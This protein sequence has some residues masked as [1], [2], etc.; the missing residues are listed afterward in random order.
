MKRRLLAVLA[1]MTLSVTLC[2]VSAWATEVGDQA[3]DL[4]DNE[5]EEEQVDD[6]EE[7][8]QTTVI[9]TDPEDHSDGGNS[10]GG[11]SSSTGG[12]SGGG[13]GSSSTG[14]SGNTGSSGSTGGSAQNANASDSSLSRLGISPG[15][16]VPAFSPNIYS[17]TVNVGE[18]VR[19][20]SIPATPNSS[21][22]VIAA[23]TG[24]KSLTPGANT[25]K[26]VVEAENGST[27][28]YTITVNC[29]SST[30]PAQQTGAN[31]GNDTAEVA[32]VEGEIIDGDTGFEDGIAGT[33]TE[34]G[35][36]SE[37]QITFDANGYLIYEGNAYIPSDL[38]PQ[39]EFVSLEKYNLLYEQQQT[40]KTRNTRA[41]LVLAL[42]ILALLIVILN[43]VLKLRDVK[44][45]AKLGLLGYDA[46]DSDRPIR[47][48]EEK[49]QAKPAKPAKPARSMVT[50]KPSRTE[51]TAKAA[52]PAKAPKTN[53]VVS[54]DAMDSTRIPDV[55]LNDFKKIKKESSDHR[56]SD[57]EI[58]DLNDL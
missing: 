37:P 20:V 45:D 49:K 27:S 30:A 41:L 4:I 55:K 13:S 56:S 34:S 26:V 28:T 54:E 58:M 42:V 19:S 43:L 17:Y 36:E 6:Q 25:V 46:T 15:T 50:E 23:V 21:K 51:K 33:D 14:N 35:Q 47:T 31:P 53:V 16:L 12:S 7:G 39:G 8:E 48:R 10:A 2:P 38:V 3:E 5:Y 11:G 9:E 22:A 52:R 40:D 1:A 29:G 32:A 18:N 24:A 57:L 44:Q